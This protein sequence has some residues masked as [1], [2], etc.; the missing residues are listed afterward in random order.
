MNQ[1]LEVHKELLTKHQR[2][3]R[4]YAPMDVPKWKKAFDLEKQLDTQSK[5]ILKANLLKDVDT[6]KRELELK[7]EENDTAF[8]ELILRQQQKISELINRAEDTVRNIST[9]NSKLSPTK[10]TDIQASLKS[11][12]TTPLNVKTSELSASTISAKSL[13]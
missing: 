8:S 5:N 12:T 10:F 2:F 9:F 1:K 6:I 3:A 11:A 7:D 13:I 4:N